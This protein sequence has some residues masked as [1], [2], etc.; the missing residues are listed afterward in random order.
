MVT[1]N[2]SFTLKPRW[3][4]AEVSLENRTVEYLRNCHKTL[5]TFL[6]RFS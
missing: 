4:I 5:I 1:L 2:T 3:F 6:F